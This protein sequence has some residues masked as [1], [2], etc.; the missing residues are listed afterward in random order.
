[1]SNHRIEVWRLTVLGWAF[2]GAFPSWP[3]ALRQLQTEDCHWQ[4]TRRRHHHR[5][6]QVLLSGAGERDQ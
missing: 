3:V 1:M 5:A 2:C 6:I 4:I